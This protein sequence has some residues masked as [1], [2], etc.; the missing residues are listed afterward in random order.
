MKESFFA[1]L[2]PMMMMFLCILAGY[3]LSK[4]KLVSG[5]ISSGLSKLEKYLFMPAM[6]FS[7]FA[8][9]CTVESVMEN[10][11][12]V[13][14]TLIGI[15]FAMIIGISL[16][17]LFEKSD[18]D[19]RNIYKYALIFA[20][21][22]F[23]GNAV[24]PLV[25]GGQEHLYKY[26]LFTLP[27]NFTTYVWG[28]NIL[29]P[30][31][32]RS[33]NPLMNLINAPMMGI[34]L[35]IIVGLT[36]TGKYV[37]GFVMTTVDAL[38]ECM[39][40]VAM[41]LTGFIIADYSFKSLLSIKKVY[42]AT[43]LRLVVIPAVIVGILILLGADKYVATLALFAYATPLGLNTVVFPASYGGDTQTGASMA[44]ISHVLSVVTISVM[45]GI[46]QSIPF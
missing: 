21:H 34:A 42:V 10:S 3:I 44:M 35:G 25:L 41:I 5:D 8:K 30:K 37:P 36:G 26:L 9:Y 23:M 13:M 1:T 38:K 17:W 19:K 16:S 33:K 7:T 28:V 15:V 43:A 27:L 6:M 39:G 11:D 4:L 29:T 40:P 12:I 31:E 2:S 24:I 18:V 22:G 32:K 45:Y 14:Y 20:N 46:L